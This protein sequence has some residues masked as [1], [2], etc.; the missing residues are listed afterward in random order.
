[1]CA[2]NAGAMSEAAFAVHGDGK[3]VEVSQHFSVC[4]N[5]MRQTAD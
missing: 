1:M 3:L 2:F 5:A 4:L